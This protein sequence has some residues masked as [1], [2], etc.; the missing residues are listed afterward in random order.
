MCLS[1]LDIKVHRYL[2]ALDVSGHVFVMTVVPLVVT[3]V[4]RPG[5]MPALFLFQVPETT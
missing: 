4:I 5:L 3:P 2:T 1:L